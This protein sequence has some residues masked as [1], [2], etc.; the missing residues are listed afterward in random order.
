MLASWPPTSGATR[1]SVA[2]TTPLISPDG[3]ERHRY[4]VAPAAMSSRPSTMIL[5]M[6]MPPCGE[7]RRYQREREIDD[8][9]QPEPAPGMRDLEEAR[10]ELVDAHDAVDREIGGEHIT[11]GEH[12]RGDRLARTGKTGQTELRQAG[13][14]EEA[15]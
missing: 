9:Q 14:E 10:A 5:G 15:H 8:D 1:T 6:P 3:P 7:R 4:Q 13:R 12:R 2:R 11:R